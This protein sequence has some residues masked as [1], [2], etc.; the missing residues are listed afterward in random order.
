MN[1]RVVVRPEVHTD[2]AE[3][4]AWY[5]ARQPGLGTEFNEQIIRVWDA[6]AENPF[7]N[8]RRHSQ[9]DI[10]WRY[11]E[12]FPYRVVYEIIEKEK[13]IVIAAVLHGARH[14]RHW[15]KRLR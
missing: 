13:L 9:R 8:S 6:V 2:I 7:L 15:L 4:A 1:W 3:T 10:R 11:P 5:E 14:E 12:S